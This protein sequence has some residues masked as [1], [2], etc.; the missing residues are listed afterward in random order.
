MVMLMGS[1]GLSRPWPWDPWVPMSAMGSHG[2][3]WATSMG[4]HGGPWGST[5]VPM[6]AH[7]S[8]CPRPWADPIMSN[9]LVG[10]SPRVTLV[11][12]YTPCKIDT[13]FLETCFRYMRHHSYLSVEI[14]SA[15]PSLCDRICCS[16]LRP[17]SK[18][19][20]C[21]LSQTCRACPHQRL[22]F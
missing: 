17:V 2:H 12:A 20:I 16:T 21:I 9:P 13:E 11:W 4:S 22:L 19:A 1:H 7:G 8:P 6:G 18:A 5:W 15:S 3:P 10:S 14:R